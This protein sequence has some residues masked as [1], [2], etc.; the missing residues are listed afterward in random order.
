M[1]ISANYYNIKQLI[2]NGADSE[3]DN[4]RT[5][6][7]GLGYHPNQYAVKDAN[8]TTQVNSDK[9]ISFRTSDYAVSVNGVYET[10]IIT[11]T[12]TKTQSASYVLK[13]YGNMDALNDSNTNKYAYKYLALCDQTVVPS[14]IG[15]KEITILFNPSKSFQSLYFTRSDRRVGDEEIVISNISI[16]RLTDLI[17]QFDTKSIKK[18]G[19]EADAGTVFQLNGNSM[20]VGSRG[21]YEFYHPN[22]DI[23]SLGISPKRKSPFIIT[24][25]YLISN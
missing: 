8:V 15:Q 25:K 1:A 16:I 9:A 23:Y 7:T 6:I 11:F 22:I 14:G 17:Q 24:A 19:I 5:S 12:I 18:I 4:Y 3:L 21:Q 20:I 10:F 2:F 13:T